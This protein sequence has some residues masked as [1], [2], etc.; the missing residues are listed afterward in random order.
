MADKTSKER[1]RTFFRIA[2]TFLIVLIVASIIIPIT[3]PRNMITSSTGNVA[4]I[5][6][7]GALS[8]QG[9]PNTLLQQGTSSSQDY[10]NM[11]GDAADAGNIKAIVLYINS[12]GGTPVAS[13]EIANAVNQAR[14]K[15][16]VIAYIREMGT[17][18]A[19]WVASSSDYIIADPL[20]LSGSVG[21]L[22]SYIDFAGLFK[23]YGISYVKLTGGE[24]KDI[25]NPYTNLTSDE[26]QLLQKRIDYMHS[27]FFNSVYKNRNLSQLNSSELDM[28][29]SGI[30]FTTD[31][32]LSYHL[33]DRAGNFDNV[34][35]VLESK[36]GIKNAK[37]AKYGFSD[38]SFSFLG[39]FKDFTVL[40]GRSAG[41][42]IGS[43]LN[44]GSSKISM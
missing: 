35:S 38:N 21:V 9:Q 2:G 44:S 30:Y 34:T 10:V 8:T 24:Y 18:G 39:V 11:I 23:K 36:Y 26:R 25:G 33:V 5:H 3:I 19:Y 41:E 29:K 42:A 14:Q 22:A 1:T 37:Y 16:P 31:E 7:S 20:A 4:L 12:P 6:I 17:S 13:E 32:A 15:K 27:I 40:L 28:I 43:S